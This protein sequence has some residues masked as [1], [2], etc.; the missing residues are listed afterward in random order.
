MAGSRV[1]KIEKERRIRVV[2]EWLL[3]DATHADIITQG[4][5][6]WG[7]SARQMQ[8]YIADAYEGFKKMTDG[9]VAHRLHY[10]I[11]RRMKLLRDLEKKNQASS[12]NVSLSILDSMA[13]LEGIM[14][15]KHEHAGKDGE[16]LIPEVTINMVS[17]PP[18]AASEK[19]VDVDR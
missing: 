4:A 10:H 8:R 13:K 16:P 11:Q 1:D 14:V 5:G 6:K 7:T 17:G 19:D 12:V 9:L 18:L 2:Q 3:S 15:S